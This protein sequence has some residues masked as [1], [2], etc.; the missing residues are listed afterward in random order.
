MHII[1]SWSLTLSLDCTRTSRANHGTVKI[2]A[3]HIIFVP[4]PDPCFGYVACAHVRRRRFSVDVGVPL[5]LFSSPFA[6]VFVLLPLWR[7]LLG[8]VALLLRLYGD[9]LLL[10]VSRQLN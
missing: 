8:L 2:Y 5:A 1:L 3:L 9:F 4:A 6:R 7:F 10:A